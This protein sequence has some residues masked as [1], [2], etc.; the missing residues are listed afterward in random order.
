MS[1]TAVPIRPLARGS[2]LK[3]W[4]GLLVLALAAGAMAWIGTSGQQVITTESG[5]RYRVVEEGT[6]PTVTP[7]D[8]VA[9]RYQLR[10]EDGTLIQDSDDTGQPFVTGTEG[11][12]PG[13]AEGLQLMQAGGRYILWLP[14]GQHVQ[15]AMPPGA[16]FTPEDTLVFEIEVLQI[17][18]GMAAMQQ[19]MGP[20]GA[21]PE[22]GAPDGAGPP[23]GGAGGTPEGPAGTNP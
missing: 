21:G 14:P 22:G 5:L 4:I 15:Q 8:L 20:P 12:F 23:P 7:A 19:M 10:K 17:A 18:P 11:V 16:P 3:L 9:L 1:V 6:G 2:V 13:F